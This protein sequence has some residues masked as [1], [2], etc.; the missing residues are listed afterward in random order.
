MEDC[1]YCEK[2]NVG[3]VTFRTK[4]DDGGT[5]YYSAVAC[6]VCGLRGTSAPINDD[7]VIEDGIAA[8]K[9]NEMVIAIKFVRDNRDNIMSMSQNMKQLLVFMSGDHGIIDSVNSLIGE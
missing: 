8:E 9:W 2:G 3:F 1:P 7:P 4:D 5:N 6:L